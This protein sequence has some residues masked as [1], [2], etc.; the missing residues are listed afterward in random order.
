MEDVLK[1]LMQQVTFYTS[2][3]GE[4]NS[5]QGIQDISLQYMVFNDKLSIKLAS[6][7]KKYTILLRS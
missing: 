4:L 7:E 1:A 6:Q 2:I 3:Y 5:I